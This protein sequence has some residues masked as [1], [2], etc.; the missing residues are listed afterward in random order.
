MLLAFAPILAL[1]HQPASPARP[2]ARQATATVRIVAGEQIRGGKA[3]DSALVRKVRTTGP[4]GVPR[5][6]RLI[7]FP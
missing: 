3:P 1:E 4:D 5:P 7:E 2:I 6:A